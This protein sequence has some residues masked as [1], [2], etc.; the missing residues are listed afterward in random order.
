[1]PVQARLIREKRFSNIA[2]GMILLAIGQ[3][4]GAVGTVVLKAQVSDLSGRLDEVEERSIQ[5]Q[6]QLR[7]KY[8]R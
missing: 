2:M 7:K 4:A 5:C 8:I 1:M 6:E 3:V